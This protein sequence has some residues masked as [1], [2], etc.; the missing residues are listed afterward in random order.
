MSSDA[1]AI[2][3]SAQMPDADIWFALPPGFMPFPVERI[4]AGEGT[5]G[6]EEHVGGPSAERLAVPDGSPGR[7]HLVPPLAP[8]RR[9]TY[10]LAWTRVIHCSVGMHR[11]DEGGDSLLLSLFTLAWRETAWA[12]RSVTAARSAAAVSDAVHREI[13]D[14]PCG[15][16]SLVETRVTPQ[17]D[18]VTQELLQATAYVP[19]PDARRL[20][21]LTL[22]TTA[23]HHSDHYRNLLRETARMVTFDNP[24]PTHDGDV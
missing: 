24:L 8:V 23:T 7:E 1:F 10:M 17:V 5:S 11:D 13:L 6:G 15:P 21:I 3:P 2:D 16:G 12:P 18:G 9:L 14:L 4:L 20:A 19:Y 22:S